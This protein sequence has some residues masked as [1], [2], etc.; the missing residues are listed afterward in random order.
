MRKG[1]LCNVVDEPELCDFCTC[2]SKARSFK[3]LFLRRD[4]SCVCQTN[5]TSFSRTF[6]EAYKIVRSGR[7]GSPRLETNADRERR[8]LILSLQLEELV[9][10]YV[11]KKEALEQSNKLFALK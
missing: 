7:T 11:Q 1:I 9:Q 5:Q 10:L 2:S 6:D 8:E 4:G 3:N